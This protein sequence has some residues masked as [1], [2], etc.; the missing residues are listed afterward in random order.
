MNRF[1]FFISCFCLD[2]LL[3]PY[4]FLRKIYISFFCIYAH[5]KNCIL[6]SNLNYSCD[7]LCSASRVLCDHDHAF[8]I[9]VFEELDI[10]AIVINAFNFHD[11]YLVN[12]WVL[13]FVKSTFEIDMLAN[14]DWYFF[15]FIL[16][17][18]NLMGGL[19]I[20]IKIGFSFASRHN[21]DKVCYVCLLLFLI[22]L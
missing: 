2:C 13:S 4:F 10:G 7:S 11:N 20:Y 22:K 12:I 1:C 21:Y 17:R 5:C 16:I 14:L 18:L 8:Y 3:W 6:F 9:I 15:L 19:I